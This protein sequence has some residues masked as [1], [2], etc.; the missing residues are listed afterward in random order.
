MPRLSLT[1]LVDVVS[2]SG[3]PKMTKVSQ[4]KNR[5][6][7]EPAFDFYK[8]IRDWIVEFHQHDR[9]KSSIG[10]ILSKVNDEKKL[11]AYP[12]IVQG[13][14]KWWGR[15]SLVWFEPPDNLF[16]SHGVDVSVNPELGLYVDNYPHIIK[17]Y[18]KA[19][20]LSKNRIDIIT[21]LM[22]VSLAGQCPEGATMSVLDV[23]RAML[24]SPTIPIPGLSAIIR[25]ELAYISTP[26]DEV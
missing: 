8:P 5:K 21:H 17:L 20:K 6:P 7:Y 22:G 14:K 26:W 25:A 10:D 9:A 2:T 13:Y 19:D 23:R 12:V 3:T 11:T 18:F 4:I 16:S 15:K 1:D 24:F